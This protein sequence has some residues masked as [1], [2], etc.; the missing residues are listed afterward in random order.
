M[1]SSINIPKTHLIMGLCLPLAVVLGYLLAEPLDSA[2]LAVVVF[3]LVILAVPLMMKWHHPLLI[4]SWN[5]VIAPAFLPGH[6]LLWMLMAVASLLFGVLNRSV[7]PDRRFIVIPSVTKSLLF[8]SAVV[9]GTAFLTGGLGFR[10]MGSSTYGGR[11]Y[12]YIA[13]A[14]LGYFAFSSQRIPKERAG[15]YLAL[16][17]LPGLTGMASNLIYMAGPS[18]YS[19]FDFFPVENAMEQASAD[20]SPTRYFGRIYGFA[21]AS[22]ALYCY[23]LARYGI[24]GSCDVTKPWR[25]LLLLAAASGCIVSG[26]RSTLILFALTFCA[27]FYLEGLHRT[28]LLAVAA[29][30]TLAFAAAVLPLADKLPLEV[31]RTLS[32]LPINVDPIIK[33]S[34]TDSTNWRLQMWKD[35]LPQVPTYLLKGK[36]YALDPN[37]MYWAAVSTAH[38]FGPGYVGT[39]FA[40]DYHNG[41][42]SVIMPFGIWGAIGFVW[43]LAASLRYLYGNYR[44]GDPQLKQIN[45]CLLAAFAAK[46]LFFTFVFGSFQNDLYFFAGLMGFSVSLNGELAA[47]V[48]EE[49]TA[50]EEEALEALFYKNGR[51]AA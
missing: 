14:V 38:S 5:A 18:F 50:E 34:A 42:L 9:V 35:V 43:F 44:L 12:A 16:F 48:A 8:L 49:R 17:F 22:P 45:T 11:N 2:S 23:V 1:A 25:G 13:A 33:R 10:S 39:I 3:V 41:P 51:D 4:L 15:L 37:A 20:A 21:I 36:G 47:Q 27:A 30:L 7:N 28:R 32:F 40:G 26:F 19:L 6:P 24:R 46:V 29:G 31:Q